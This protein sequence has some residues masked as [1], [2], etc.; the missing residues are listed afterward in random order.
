MKLRRW[1]VG[2][3]VVLSLLGAGCGDDDDEGGDDF[4]SQVSSQ[5]G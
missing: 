5:L 2:L 1:V 3:I 4:T